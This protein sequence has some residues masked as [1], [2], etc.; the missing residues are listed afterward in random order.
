M[1]KD[2][3]VF[4]DML[5]YRSTKWRREWKILWNSGHAGVLSRDYVS[6]NDLTTDVV[7]YRNGPKVAWAQVL[8]VLLITKAIAD[9][10]YKGAE[11]V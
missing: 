4:W 1:F 10:S 8:I 6:Y 5:R 7:V 2:Y 3:I 11:D 9:V